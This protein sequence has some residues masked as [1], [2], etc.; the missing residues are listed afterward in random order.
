MLTTPEKGILA[1]L[2][3]ATATAFLLPIVRRVRIVLAGAPED[4]S[5]AAPSGRSAW[6]RGFS[7]RAS[8]TAP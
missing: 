5:N 1:L 7:T 6:P 2:I 3:L 8:S 4:C